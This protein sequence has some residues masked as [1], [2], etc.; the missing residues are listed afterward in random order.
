MRKLFLV[1]AL[2]LPLVGCES[3]QAPTVPTALESNANVS[4]TAV[5]AVAATPQQSG[6][7]C[8]SRPPF[9]ATIDVFVVAGNVSLFVTGITTEFV[10]Q[11]GV[12]SVTLPAPVPTTQFGSTLVQARASVTLPVNVSFGC[13]TTKTGTV[14]MTVNLTDANGFTSARHLSVNV[15]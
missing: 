2:V 9:T 6:F 13:G 3:R 12:S 15:H 10:D 8:P 4:V 1:G 14:A 11:N 5:S 7:S